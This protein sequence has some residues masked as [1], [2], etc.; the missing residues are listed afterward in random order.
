M[1]IGVFEKHK[2]VGRGGVGRAATAGHH[3]GACSGTACGINVVFYVGDVW[4]GL[5]LPAT[6]RVVPVHPNAQG[7]GNFRLEVEVSHIAIAI[8][9]QVVHQHH[10]ACSRPGVALMKIGGAGFLRA[11]DGQRPLV[12][13]HPLQQDAQVQVVVDALAV[14]RVERGCIRSV[15]RTAIALN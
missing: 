14:S 6:F 5:K 13:G 15:G 2:A 3:A 1:H 8:S 11:T 9:E 7:A 4:G 10:H 12:A